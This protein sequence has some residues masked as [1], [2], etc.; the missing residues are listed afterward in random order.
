MRKSVVFTELQESS[1]HKTLLFSGFPSLNL[2]SFTHPSFL[3]NSFGLRLY[4]DTEHVLTN[5]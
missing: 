2:R 4:C 1:V 5:V 3:L